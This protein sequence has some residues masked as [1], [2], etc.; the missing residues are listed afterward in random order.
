MKFVTGF[1]TLVSKYRFWI[2][3]GFLG[4]KICA[5]TSN[6]VWSGDFW[7][8]S[9]VVHSLM[10]DIFHPQHPFLTDHTSHAFLSPYSI[11]VSVFANLFKTD[12]ITALSIAGLINYALFCISLLFF[13]N[14]IYSKVR[15]AS[16]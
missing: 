15:L 10:L 4:F 14:S 16:C 8:H 7:E 12:S 13:I 5:D 3:S 2:L 9:A 6:G 1:I 11:L